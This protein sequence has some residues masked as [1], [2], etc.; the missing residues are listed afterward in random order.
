M[1]DFSAKNIPFKNMKIQ[2]FPFQ[3]YEPLFFKDFLAKNIPF[4]NESPENEE[5]R[6]SYD[7]HY[8]IY[9]LLITTPYMVW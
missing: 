7:L 2:K 3:N 6:E 5:F 4:E 9:S 1:N 8:I